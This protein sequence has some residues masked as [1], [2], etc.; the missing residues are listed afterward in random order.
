M[1]FI[2]YAFI[3]V[4]NT[5][6]HVSIFFTIYYIFEV[7]QSIS[8]FC[9]FISAASFSYFIN[10]KYNFKSKYNFRKYLCFVLL[11]G[12]ISFVIGCI[13]DKNQLNPVVTMIF[14]TFISLILGFSLSK[15]FIFKG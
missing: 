1:N 4:I 3:G 14:F 5:F 12:I 11:M 10:S 15:Y 6:I 7:D 2:K 9:A 8:N 13:S